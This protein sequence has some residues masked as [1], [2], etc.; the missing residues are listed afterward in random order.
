MPSVKVNLYAGLRGFIGGK[1]SVAV[2]IRPGQSIK[3]VLAGVGIPAELTHILFVNGRAA[4]LDSP[5][6]DGDQLGVFPAIGGG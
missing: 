5:L 6:N 2:E 1:A 4:R 3:E